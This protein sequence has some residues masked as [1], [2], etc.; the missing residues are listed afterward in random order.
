MEREISLAR[1]LC[2]V[3]RRREI[4]NIYSMDSC[5]GCG[6]KIDGDNE[7][8]SYE[9]KMEDSQTVETNICAIQPAHDK[10][11]VKSGIIF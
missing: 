6:W 3:V 11:S 5:P 4:T 1:A 10:P 9:I 8:V 7:A 2:K